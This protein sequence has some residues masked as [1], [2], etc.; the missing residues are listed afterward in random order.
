[1]LYEV[2]TDFLLGYTD[3]YMKTDAAS[4]AANGGA[5]DKIQTLNAAPTKLEAST[6]ISEERL[7]SQFLRLN[8]NYDLKYLVSLRNNFV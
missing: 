3:L 2:I 8:Y 5:S 1:M 6:S 4:L 7:I